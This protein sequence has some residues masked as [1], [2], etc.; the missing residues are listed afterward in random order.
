M[1]IKPFVLLAGSLSIFAYPN[2]GFA[3]KRSDTQSC[4]AF[5][6]NPSSTYSCENSTTVTSNS[7]CFE[8]AG[9]MLHTQFWDYDPDKLSSAKKRDLGYSPVHR[10]KKRSGAPSSSYPINKSFTI[11]GLWSDYCATSSGK[12]AGYPASCDADLAVPDS[13]NLSDL[14]ANQFN[15]PDLYQL[16][17]TYWV[18][19]ESSN[20]AGDSDEELWAHEY[21]KHGT[22]MNTVRPECFTGVYKQYDAAVE[23]WQ[24]VTKVWDGLNTY[25]F[26][27]SAS[28]VP[29]TDN[30]YE[31]VDIKSA[32]QEAFGKDVYVS[33]KDGALNEIWYYY[34]VKGSIL[35]GDYKPV[36]KIG[37]DR[38]PDEV[39]YIPK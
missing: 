11:H 17:K 29:T 31:L 27:E 28:I 38:C 33:C 6:A 9:L 5:M 4:S 36:D 21:N 1:F 20:V 19:T 23:F 24:K 26:L 16:M 15:K 10:N 2:P 14:I 13:V 30:T 34:H 22:C 25:E 32:L 7:C 12:S 18:N 39:Y 35:T 37:S 3:A 8:R